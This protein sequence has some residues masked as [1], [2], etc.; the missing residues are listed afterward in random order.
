MKIYG[1]IGNPLSHSFS[2]KYFTEK[3]GNENIKDCGYQNFEIKNLQVEIPDLKNN[4]LISGLNVTIPYK[5]EII[6]YLDTVSKECHEINACNCIKTDDGKW[7]GYNTDTTGFEKSFVPYLQPHNTKALILGTGGSS[8]AIAYVLK[9][10]KIDFLFVS[11]KKDISADIINYES[12]S[13]L[14]MREYSIMINTTP[15]GMFPNV[16]DYPQLPYGY[17]SEKHYFFDLVYNP[18]KTIFLSKAEEMGAVIKNGA[19]ML[20]IQ[21]DESWKIWNNLK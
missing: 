13:S 20:T 15:A 9:K 11:R 6:Q 4:P 17:V 1:L 18:S 2:K 5:S 14:M 3:F 19:D 21:A 7:T 16:D 12:I 10:I 8:K